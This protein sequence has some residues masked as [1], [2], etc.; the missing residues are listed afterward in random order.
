MADEGV[1]AGDVG[2]GTIGCVCHSLA[3]CMPQELSPDSS[4]W[5]KSWV[6]FTA[7][8]TGCKN[9]VGQSGKT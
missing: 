9:S 2:F 1:L 3:V 7:L 8:V 5:P 4:S 6:S